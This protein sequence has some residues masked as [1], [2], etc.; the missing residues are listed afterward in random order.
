MENTD[1]FINLIKTRN[2][3]NRETANEI[4]NVILNESSTLSNRELHSGIE[5]ILKGL[6][7]RQHLQFLFTMN[8]P[9]R[10]ANKTFNLILKNLFEISRDNKSLIFL[11]KECVSQIPQQIK[12]YKRKQQK[13]HVNDILDEIN[14]L[15]EFSYK[16]YTVKAEYE[17][18]TILEL[19]AEFITLIEKFPIKQNTIKYFTMLFNIF[20]S[21]GHLFMAANVLYRLLKVESR[22]NLTMDYVLTLIDLMKIKDNEEEYHK[23]LCSLS[24]I[25]DQQFK[26][27]IDN[28]IYD[29]DIE[30]YLENSDLQNFESL[31]TAKGK[32]FKMTEDFRN[33]VAFMK[34]NNFEYFIEDGTFFFNGNFKKKSNSK[35]IFEIVN[36]IK[37]KSNYIDS[38]KIEEK[39]LRHQK[40]REESIKTQLE[41]TRKAEIIPIEEQQIVVE[42][43]KR[44]DFFTRRFNFFRTYQMSR[45]FIDSEENLVQRQIEIQNEYEKEVY[46][47][48]LCCIKFYEREEEI[49]N[50]LK[51]AEMSQKAQSDV[52]VKIIADSDQ[53][54]ESSWRFASKDTLLREIR[55][56]EVA[57]ESE[58]EYKRKEPITPTYV[59]PTAQSSLRAFG[60]FSSV[61]PQKANATSTYDP[62]GIFGTLKNA[63]PRKQPLKTD[64]TTQSGVYN[65]P[66]W[67]TDIKE[68]ENSN[69]Y[70]PPSFGS[71]KISESQNQP[72]QS[73]YVTSISGTDKSKRLEAKTGH[74]SEQKQFHKPSF[75]QNKTYDTQNEYRPSYKFSENKDK[76]FTPKHISNDNTEKNTGMYQPPD[77]YKPK[78]IPGQDTYQPPNSYKPK[79]IPGQ[80]T[81]QPPDSYK[82]KVI[83]G[84]DTY[85]PPDSYKPKV[86][87]GQD[88]YQPPRFDRKDGYQS[89]FSQ[90]ETFQNKRDFQRSTYKPKSS[91]YR[92]PAQ[93]DLRTGSSSTVWY[94]DDKKHPSI[95]TQEEPEK[96]QG[97]TNF[98]SNPFA[99]KN[100]E[101]KTQK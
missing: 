26:S 63:S 36:K 31:L 78:V 79:V 5:S 80:D 50:L 74:I 60:D 90:R 85:Q 28:F 30:I 62:S 16:L 7:E 13:S 22:T 24:I 101:H 18:Y 44:E 72:S 11:F 91:Q 10:N 1:K 45:K 66:E 76:K 12:F 92:P 93:N 37:E 40:E 56:E 49:M 65:V 82:P 52:S 95:G 70:K 94:T 25:T 21:R 34:L 83:P 81:Y 29:Q 97:S 4:K 9:K 48:E 59:P 54:L 38:R 89:K 64:V 14:I 2:L 58:Q 77:S 51:E 71:L 39:R 33:Y 27:E 6:D 41:S 19:V 57:R 53:K 55:N 84:Q 68:P 73:K 42:E 35:K 3:G 69:V 96:K 46:Q 75:R 67:R 88:T 43:E 86:I 15:I 17:A 8:F 20:I 23:M 87:P 99:M 32:S 61:L 98:S 100:S 47:H